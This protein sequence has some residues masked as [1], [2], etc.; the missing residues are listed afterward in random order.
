MED[1]LD[2]REDVLLR[3]EGHL[4]V[5]LVELARRAIRAAVLVAEARRD[6]EVAVEP[7]GHQELLE[8]LGRLRQRVELSRM[9][10]AWHQVVSCPFGRARREDRRL[11]LGEPRLDHPA[12]DGRDDAAAQHDVA[13]ELLAPK[14]EKPVA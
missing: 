4:E 11:E 9:H 7:G 10:P 6:L 14:V 13:M 8:L 12:A 3:D 5:E 2:R 1:R